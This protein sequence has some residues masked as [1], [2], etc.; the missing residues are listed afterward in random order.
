MSKLEIIDS[1]LH[2]SY[3]DSSGV[4]VERNTD[5]KG[6]AFV[7]QR[8]IIAN[9]DVNCS[10]YRYDNQTDLFPF[11]KNHGVSKLKKMCDYVLF[12]EEG[13]HLFTYL[14][15]LKKGTESAKIQLDA[16]ECFVDYI[17]STTN[18]LELKL[19]INENNF[20]LRKIRVSESKSKKK[21][22][23]KGIIEKENGVIEHE[24]S[25]DFHIARY[26]TY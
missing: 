1:I 26:L 25:R 21:T 18:R 23:K 14:V 22:L 24:N 12:I 20:H 10:V 7:M 13:E 11:F 2:E 4:L 17:I 19:G 3:K 16:G 9:K 6:N 8:K 15:E 5:N